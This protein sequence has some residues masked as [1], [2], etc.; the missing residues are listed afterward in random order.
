M[1]RKIIGFSLVCGL[2]YWFCIGLWDKDLEFVGGGDALFYDVEFCSYGGNN[3][4]GGR[5]YIYLFNVI[6]WNCLKFKLYVELN[7][8]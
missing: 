1:N 5:R 7:I 6:N 8:C 4:R 2:M 3:W